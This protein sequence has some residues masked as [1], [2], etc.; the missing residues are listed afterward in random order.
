MRRRRRVGD[1]AGRH[2]ARSALV[3]YALAVGHL[4]NVGA[5]DPGRGRDRCSFIVGARGGVRDSSRFRVSVLLAHAVPGRT[6]QLARCGERF[7]V[8]LLRKI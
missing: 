7:A 1:L 6:I 2:A 8:D 4:G 3:L 5:H